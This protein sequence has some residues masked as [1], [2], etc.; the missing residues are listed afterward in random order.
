[1][2]GYRIIDK[3]RSIDIKQ[4]LCIFNL[5]EKVKECRENHSEHV[6]RMPTNQIPLK[7][8]DQHPK[9]RRETGRP[10]KKWKDQFV[11]PEDWNRSK[12][13][14]LMMVMMI[15]RILRGGP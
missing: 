12:G 13:L 8:F 2:A 9:G 6:L 5:G 15:L 4:E 14:E 1:V 11:K 3:K 7:L 10:R